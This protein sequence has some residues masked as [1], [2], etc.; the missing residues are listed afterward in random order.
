MPSLL[1]WIDHDPAEQE[2][3]QQILALFQIRDT[4]DEL[5]IGAIR[6]SF[7]DQLFPGTSTIQTRL[8]YML[9]VPWLY[10]AMEAAR[11][12]SARA[13]SA[14][15]QRE[16]ALS[17]ALVQTGG[18][19]VFGRT[20]GGSL[21]R[22]ASS[23]YWAGLGTWGIRLFRGSQE[24]YHRALDG[25]YRRR[26]MAMPG[27][28]G[29]AGWEASLE[30]WHPKLPVPPASFPAEADFRLTSGEADFLRERIVVTAPESLL[31]YLMVSGRP[32]AVEFAW[33]HPDLTS[34]P[35]SARELLHHARLFSEVMHGAAILYNLMLAELAESSGMTEEHRAR[36]SAWEEERDCQA[37]HAWDLPRLW[38]LASRSTH[39]ITPRARAFVTAWVHLL[40]SEP[41]SLAENE[42][43]RLLVLRRESALKGGRSRFTNHSVREQWSGYAG[44]ERLNYRWATVKSYLDDMHRA[45]SGGDGA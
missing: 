22:P 25:L 21:K 24:Q 43:A 5:G 13:A 7:A 16:F 28:E 37:V 40:R 4:R 1:A 33:L 2:R 9:F 38:D 44:L 11:I 10:T 29:D 30:T 41:S 45:R 35:P 19:G 15:R 23:V 8:R 17:E 31:A 6:D 32:A 18:L 27:E 39:A 42:Q 3:M 12:P 14:M 26:D 20:S 34:F 36:L